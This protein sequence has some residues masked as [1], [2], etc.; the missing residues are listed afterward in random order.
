MARAIKYRQLT[1]TARP[2]VHLLSLS[3]DVLRYIIDLLD[4]RDASSF[5]QTSK[6]AADAALFR[7]LE[8]FAF[9]GTRIAERFRGLF[10]QPDTEGHK[11]TAKDI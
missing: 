11:A 1:K 8:S 4:K 5:R 9:G 7:V 2:P 3:D 10:G 6:V